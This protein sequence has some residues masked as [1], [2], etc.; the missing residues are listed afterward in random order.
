MKR[1]AGIVFDLPL[2]S[3]SPAEEVTLMQNRNERIRAAVEQAENMCENRMISQ[4]VARELEEE[5]PVEDRYAFHMALVDADI[6][7]RTGAQLVRRAAPG[8]KILRVPSVDQ[9]PG[10]CGPSA[11]RAVLAF[12]GVLKSED[13]LAALA[14]SDRDEGT[15]VEGMLAAARALGFDAWAKDDASLDE[16]QKLV[17][18]GVPVI[19]DWFSSTEGHYSPVIGID[20]ATVRL[21]DPEIAQ[22]REMPRHDFDNVW[23]DFEGDAPDGRLVKRRIIVVQPKRTAAV[24]VVDRE[25]PVV[26]ELG[27]AFVNST[28]LW[29]ADP[30][31]PRDELNTDPDA[32]TELDAG[33]PRRSEGE[34]HEGGGFGNNLTDLT[35]LASLSVAKVAQGYGEG[36]FAV[37]REQMIAMLNRALGLEYSQA[38]RYR[39]YADTLRLA[40]RDALAEEFEDHADEETEHAQALSAKIV[41]L[42]GVLEPKIE[43]PVRIAPN[44]PDLVGR[45]LRELWKQEQEGIKFYRELKRALGEN[46][47]VHYIE[48][49]LTAESEHADD[50]VRFTQVTKSAAVVPLPSYPA[51]SE[52]A[53]W[54]DSYTSENQFE[55]TDK[56]GVA[57]LGK[58]PHC[59]SGE[60]LGNVCEKCSGKTASVVRALCEGC[61]GFGFVKECVTCGQTWA[62]P[63]MLSVGKIASWQR[64]AG[65]VKRK[66]MHGEIPVWIE[67]DAGD[68]KRG[69]SRTGEAWER[70]MQASYGFIPG[71]RGADGEPVDVYLGGNPSRSVYV[72]SQLVPG[73]GFDEEKVML[74]FPNAQQ[75]EAMY[76]AHMP[77]N[78]AKHFGGMREMSVGEFEDEYLRSDRASP[79]KPTLQLRQF[80]VTGQQMVPNPN[81]EGREDMVTQEYA[82]QWKAEHGQGGSAESPAEKSED[83]VFGKYKQDKAKAQVA[84]AVKSLDG[85][86]TGDF[87]RGLSDKLGVTRQRATQVMQQLE[88]SGVISKQVTVPDEKSIDP[89]TKQP[90][91]REVVK[92]DVGKL[93][94]VPAVEAEPAPAAPEP[95]QEAPAV[96]EPKPSSSPA[97]E[98]PAAP[99]GGQAPEQA[100]PAPTA[101]E[102]A[103]E[104]PVART[105]RTLAGSALERKRKREQ[106]A[107]KPREQVQ[108]E[109]DAAYKF[110]YEKGGGDSGG[111]PF[112]REDFISAM[113]ESGVSPEAAA[114]VLEEL[115]IGGPTWVENA[116]VKRKDG[117]FAFAPEPGFEPKLPSVDTSKAVS[118]ITQEDMRD[119]GKAKELETQFWRLLGGP[120]FNPYKTSVLDLHR[121][122]RRVIAESYSQPDHGPLGTDGEPDHPTEDVVVQHASRGA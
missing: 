102:P 75:A 72:V 47:F 88:A 55:G 3:N 39:I 91:K 99:A 50:L 13:E 97:V 115:Q 81:P 28:N 15:P 113:G 65:S 59:E 24:N 23:F 82:D 14:G 54:G 114:D 110:L 7:V 87:V 66:V 48:E 117:T 56:M 105:E 67:Y 73:S 68:V 108:Q 8:G 31:M 29:T 38:L 62:P 109:S 104:A 12:F 112:T 1:N 89:K 107:K 58:C 103:Q 40:Y 94:H 20:D 37:S 118:P 9:T 36:A 45:V 60:V 74:G 26:R 119:Q 77:N 121:L 76:R 41:A 44:D 90:A 61:D 11:L 122:A 120:G 25:E 96:E 69:K 80:S 19:V 42:G 46:I 98:P 33:K 43:E 85:A 5:L 52:P 106:W 57:E 116:V 10:F 63:P 111:V 71:T 2:D 17:Q 34:K 18:S 84:S 6:R 78:G 92:V 79:Y 100:A 32:T 93:K 70:K 64:R 101:P 49:V 21:Q 35:M 4:D 86:K 53:R 16:L 51:R 95:A 30:A 83:D 27:D 22:P